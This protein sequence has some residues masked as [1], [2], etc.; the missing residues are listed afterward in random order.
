MVSIWISE[1]YVAKLEQL[2]SGGLKPN[3]RAQTK[4]AI[5]S[6]ILVSGIDA[7]FRSRR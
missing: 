2:A 6:E 7:R 5:A 4:S 3:G 1:E